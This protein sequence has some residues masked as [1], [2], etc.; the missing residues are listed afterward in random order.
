[1]QTTQGA[2][3]PKS[4]YVEIHDSK[5]SSKDRG[6]FYKQKELFFSEVK[7]NITAFFLD[8]GRYVFYALYA[9]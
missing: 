3:I 2:Y 6:S 5:F 4:G 7:L 8:I 9:R 1:M